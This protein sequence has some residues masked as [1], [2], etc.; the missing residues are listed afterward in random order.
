VMGFG[1]AVWDQLFKS[2]RPV[3]LHPFRAFHAGFPRYERWKSGRPVV[4]N[5][6]RMR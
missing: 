3:G 5:R 6:H 4:E 1:S 2:A